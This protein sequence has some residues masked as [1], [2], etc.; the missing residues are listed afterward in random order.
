MASADSG[1]DLIDVNADKIPDEVNPNLARNTLLYPIGK[2]FLEKFPQYRDII[3]TYENSVESIADIVGK[4]LMINTYISMND[5]MFANFKFWID[6]VRI[7]PPDS[8]EAAK[9]SNFKYVPTPNIALATKGLYSCVILGNINYSYTIYHRKK[10]FSN[11]LDLISSFK[12]NETNNTYKSKIENAYA[13]N[14]PIPIGCK[15]CALNHYDPVTLIKT[16]EEMKSMFGY[17][18]VDGF[19]RN[20][21]P[22]YKNPFNKPIIV[23]NNFDE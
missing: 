8:L 12:S 18:I 15:W 7:F 20:I 21:I 6:N 4:D 16:G 2:S 10:Q 5:T 19:L 1:H 13:V 9:Y 22:L 23:K 14:M 17:F 11:Y 3:A